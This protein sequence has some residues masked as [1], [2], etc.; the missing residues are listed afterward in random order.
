[1]TFDQKID[2]FKKRLIERAFKQSD[3]TVSQ[4]A[5]LLGMNRTTLVMKLRVLRIKA[6]Y[7]RPVKPDPDRVIENT[8]YD[9]W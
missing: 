2:K 8:G 4:T 7:E 1:M 5:K 3:G 6:E 9:G